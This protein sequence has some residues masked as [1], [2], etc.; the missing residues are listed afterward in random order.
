MLARAIKYATEKHQLQK[1]KHMQVPFID[2]SCD[3]PGV[4]IERNGE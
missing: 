1:R 4:P 3:V 2:Q